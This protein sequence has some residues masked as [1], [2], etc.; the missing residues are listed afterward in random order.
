MVGCRSYGGKFLAEER[1]EG[2]A[3]RRQCLNASVRQSE[4]V[5]SGPHRNSRSGGHTKPPPPHSHRTHANY[6]RLSS[7]PDSLQ[8][9]H[10]TVHTYLCPHAN[11]A[12][13]RS[14]PLLHPLNAQA[15]IALFL[16][17]SSAT[18]AEHPL[19]QSR[20]DSFNLTKLLS[21]LYA[22]RCH[23]VASCSACNPD[24]P[25]SDRQTHPLR[26]PRTL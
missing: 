11:V 4:P 19:P 5:L 8:P 23:P 3:G 15:H 14:C 2:D 22:T 21:M 13:A 17:V 20:L 16:R 25:A 1:R 12:Q 24:T 26:S 10:A 9:N 6:S 7:S 18:D